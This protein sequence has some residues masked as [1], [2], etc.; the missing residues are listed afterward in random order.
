MA[1]SKGWP[2]GE[3]LAKDASLPKITAFLTAIWVIVQSF[4]TFNWWSPIA[5]LILGWIFA[6][7]LTM[8]LKKNI[9]FIC[10]VGIFPALFFTILYISEDKPFGMLHKL[11]S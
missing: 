2:V 4:I 3:I 1:R 11:F 7:L 9:Q 5:I 6:F 10:I 8:T